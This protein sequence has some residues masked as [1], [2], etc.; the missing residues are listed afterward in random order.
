VQ[1]D[2]RAAPT[3]SSAEGGGDGIRELLILLEELKKDVDRY[4]R[5]AAAAEDGRHLDAAQ[6]LRRAPNLSSRLVQALTTAAGA[7][8]ALPLESNVRDAARRARL[9][10]R[11]TL[12]RH[13]DEAALARS[14]QWPSYVI[15]DVLRLQFDLERGE[16]ALNAKG[17]ETL[18]P[19]RVVEHIKARLAELFDKSLDASEFLSLLKAAHDQVTAAHGR[20]MGDYANIREVFAAVRTAIEGSGRDRRGRPVSTAARWASDD[21]RW[22]ASGTQSRTERRRRSVRPGQG[23]RQL[24]RRSP[25]RVETDQWLMASVRPIN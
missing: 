10:Y 2:M 1:D 5:I 21:T 4:M 6:G 25:L 13:L 14:G 22:V 3:P 18:D 8:Q 15:A 11:E 24:H 9:H 7:V 23:R 12:E 20:G 19:A 16:V 17:L